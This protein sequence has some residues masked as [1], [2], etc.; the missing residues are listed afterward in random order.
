MDLQTNQAEP[1]MMHI[2]LNGAFATIE[3]QAKPLLRGKAVAVAANPSVRGTII[4]PSYE[5]KAFGI[6]TGHRVFQGQE[7]YPDLIVLH[8]DP[9]KYFHVHKEFAKI[10]RE[11][12]PDVVALSIDEAVINFAGTERLHG[13]SLQEIGYEIKDRIRREIGDW[14]SCNV[15][16]GTNRFLSKTAASLHKP[17]GLDTITHDNLRSIYSTLSLID[18]CG[19]NFRYEKRL[20]AAGIY[21]P[22]EFLDAPLWKLKNEV[23]QSIV[24]YYWYLRLRGFEV[25]TAKHGRKTYGQS[26]HL[27]KF[28]AD[29]KGLSGLVMKLCE[30]MG[31][32]LRRAGMAARGVAIGCLLRDGYWGESK[33][34][35]DYLDSTQDFYE[36][37]NGFVEP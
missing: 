4:S 26:Y 25:D 31:R 11:Y 18:L 20:K 23:F 33:K 32:R 6:K 30:K 28:T 21:T 36:K 10:F 13:K 5:A 8:A 1:L 7:L 22:L 14:I 29:T 15:G 2:D 34:S 19:I 16:I 17:D 9:D 3:Q 24:G 37:G 35:A 27:H 12:S